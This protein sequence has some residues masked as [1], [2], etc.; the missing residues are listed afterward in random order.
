[1][2]EQIKKTDP[3]HK[4]PQQSRKSNKKMSLCWQVQQRLLNA[5]NLSKIQNEDLA[6]Y[7]FWC[8]IY[9]HV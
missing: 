8:N 3:T 9:R 4:F 6:D 1:M 7:N 5:K 2:G